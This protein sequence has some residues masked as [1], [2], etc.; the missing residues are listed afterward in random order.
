[1]HKNNVL[2]SRDIS[3]TLL[4]LNR[5]LAG[6]AK[7]QAASWVL[8]QYGVEYDQA[9]LGSEC[10][11]LQKSVAQEIHDLARD[12]DRQNNNISH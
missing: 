11:S 2:T 5:N 9:K 7:L 4:R 10:D 8:S 3:R 12:L 1:M 6:A